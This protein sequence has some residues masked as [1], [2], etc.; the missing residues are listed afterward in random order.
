MARLGV[1][2]LKAEFVL[3]G[4]PLTL[5]VA[6]DLSMT[7]TDAGIGGWMVHGEIDNEG[8]AESV[9]CI[10]TAELSY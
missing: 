9:D 6:L 1:C 7:G 2:L 4:C 8:L 3:Q 5:L 10:G